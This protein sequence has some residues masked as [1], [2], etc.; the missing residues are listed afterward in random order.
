[1][2]YADGKC[3]VAAKSEHTSRNDRLFWN[4][5]M[6]A[7]YKEGYSNSPSFHLSAIDELMSE[8]EQERNRIDQV[9]YDHIG[10]IAAVNEALCA[11]RYHPSRQWMSRVEDD[12]M[13]ISGK[14][15]SLKITNVTVHSLTGKRSPR[16]L[17]E[18]LCAAQTLSKIQPP[19]AS[20]SRKNWKK[21]KEM[22]E[23]LSD[24]WAVA[25]RQFV[26][27]FRK[28]IGPQRVPK[29]L[30]PVD[31]RPLEL[32]LD[33]EYLN[34][35]QEEQDALLLAIETK[36]NKVK[37][38]TQTSILPAPW[39]ELAFPAGFETEPLR[40]TVAPPKIKPKTRPSTEPALLPRIDEQAVPDE[41]QPLPVQPAIPV[42]PK[43]AQL[44]AQMFSPSE[45]RMGSVKWEDLVAAMV[46]A[47]CSATHRGGSVVTFKD[48]RN[49]MG[50][51]TVHKPHPDPSVPPIMLKRIGKRLNK[52]LGWRVE[53]FEERGG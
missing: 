46:D 43:S 27:K 8:S 29:H 25:R 53:T 31:T 41:E 22:H 2:S 15:N 4:L 19:T 23:A 11:I 7:H 35:F 39:S 44:F 36:E 50:L 37:A 16:K 45:H 40:E 5:E 24:Y 49:G 51:I 18:L 48:E 34:E 12:A 14:L 13:Q 28:T 6:L 20:I 52:W 10:D 32:G 1:M 38:N 30:V 47:G 17:E 42:S 9:M 33:E 26:K 3:H 21:R